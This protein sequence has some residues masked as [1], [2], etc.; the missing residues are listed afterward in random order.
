MNIPAS[1]IEAFEPHGLPKLNFLKNLDTTTLE[2]IL[3]IMNALDKFMKDNADNCFMF[4]PIIEEGKRQA[5]ADH[6]CG[7]LE[8][9]AMKAGADIVHAK[10]RAMLAEYDDGELVPVF[11]TA[12][13]K[14]KKLETI[15][16]MFLVDFTVNDE[17]TN[18]LL[19][20]RFK[21]I[22]K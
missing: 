4:A 22:P 5:L 17:N 10:G 1:T 6:L 3:E 20:Y 7:W 2:I 8:E 14:T 21:N 13:R 9:T 16:F 18:H 15:G 11:A 12:N 19:D